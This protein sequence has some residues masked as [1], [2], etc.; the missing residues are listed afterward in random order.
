MSSIEQFLPM[1]DLMDFQVSNTR[2][3]IAHL[4]D[5]GD[6]EADELKEDMFLQLLSFANSL[7]TELTI[8]KTHLEALKPK[9][10]KE[11]GEFILIL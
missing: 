8:F 11:K 6:E 2:P 5:A 4:D 3:S 9:K 1:N 7:N 10:Q